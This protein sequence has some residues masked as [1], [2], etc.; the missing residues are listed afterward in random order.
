MDNICI[1]RRR[2][3]ILAGGDDQP[4]A[5][6]DFYWFPFEQA[7]F[8][9]HIRPE[10]VIFNTGRTLALADRSWKDFLDF[11][12]SFSRFGD[13]KVM[14]MILQLYQRWTEPA[15]RDWVHSNPLATSDS[16]SDDSE[17]EDDESSNE[18]DRSPPRA[19][20]KSAE[21]ENLGRGASGAQGGAPTPSPRTSDRLG[22]ERSPGGSGT[23]A[24]GHPHF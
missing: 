4:R 14:D 7:S 1:P 2:Q 16:C 20:P 9:S 12:S 22:L 18:A 24:I 3:T 19:R 15:P 17:K 8:T 23:K 6:Y 5:Q 11:Y 21:P 10:Y 13:T